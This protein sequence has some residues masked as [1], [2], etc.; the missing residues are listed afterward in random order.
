MIPGFFE[1]FP[2]LDAD[3]KN[4]HR[5]TGAARQHDRTRFGDVAWAARAINGKRAVVAFFDAPSHHRQAAQSSTRRTP[6]RGAVSHPLDYFA[7]PLS[8]ERSGVHHHNAT[9][10][11]PPH[12]GNNHAV[13][14]RPDDSSAARIDIFG[15]LPAQHLETQRRAEDANYGGHQRRNQWNLK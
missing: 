4:D 10:A 3:V 5:S 13:P 2:V 1:S 8:V 11:P 15:I 14:K 12:H 9:V 6:L 7:R